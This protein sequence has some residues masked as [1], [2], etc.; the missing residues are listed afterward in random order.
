MVCYKLVSGT[1]FTRVRENP[2]DSHLRVHL[3]FA[4]LVQSVL[5]P[6]LGCRIG[7]HKLLVGQVKGKDR[8]SCLAFCLSTKSNY[9]RV[10]QKFDCDETFA[11]YPPG[12]DLPVNE[13]TGESSATKVD[14]IQCD[15]T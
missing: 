14:V 13:S 7:Q 9:K 4:A 2:C 10:N 3:I 6:L 11:T 8:P 1:S 12:F 15:A 5:C